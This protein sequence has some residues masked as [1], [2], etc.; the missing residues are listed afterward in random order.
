MVSHISRKTSEMPRISCTQRLDEAA[1]APFFKERR[2]KF[3][4]PIR[5]HRK[6]GVWGTPGFLAGIDG[7]W[8][9]DAQLVHIVSVDFQS[10]HRRYVVAFLLDKAM[11]YHSGFGCLLEDWAVVDGALPQLDDR[12]HILDR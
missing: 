8:L 12:R 3:E 2:M 9:A 1:C 5:F 7:P 4:K 10:F 6:S 11:L